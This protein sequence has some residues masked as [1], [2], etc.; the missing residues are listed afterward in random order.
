MKQGWEVAAWFTDR[1][2]RIASNAIDGKATREQYDQA[3]AERQAVLDWLD[4]NGYE[5]PGPYRS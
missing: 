2:T 5:V 1:S 3:K 4:A